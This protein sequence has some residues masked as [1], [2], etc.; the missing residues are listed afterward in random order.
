MQGMG[1]GEA[2]LV[3]KFYIT[4][5]SAME[6]RTLVRL[7][8]EL[9]IALCFEHG[10]GQPVSPVWVVRIL[11]VRLL[12]EWMALCCTIKQYAKFQHHERMR[13]MVKLNDLEDMVE[14]PLDGIPEAS[15][16]TIEADR[17][18]GYGS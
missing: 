10:S 16:S 1:N 8:R 6:H 3:E 17:G 9:Q 11:M 5:N 7:E 4:E 12:R 15:S 18:N 13:S 14:P 2:C